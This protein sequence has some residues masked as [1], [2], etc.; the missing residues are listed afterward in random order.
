MRGARPTADDGPWQR[1]IRV[2]HNVIPCHWSLAQPLNQPLQLAL[3]R[4]KAL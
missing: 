4:L 3:N 1:R 2:G